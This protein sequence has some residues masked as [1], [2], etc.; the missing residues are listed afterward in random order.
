MEKLLEKLILEMNVRKNIVLR[1]SQAQFPLMN[2][3]VKNV[4][5]RVGQLSNIRVEILPEIKHP[6]IILESEN[7]LI[8]G[9]IEG[10][11]RNID[12]IFEQVVSDE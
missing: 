4:E 10:V 8:D 1:V 6:G 5:Q 11:F 2:D 12:K 3:I 7:G 9:S